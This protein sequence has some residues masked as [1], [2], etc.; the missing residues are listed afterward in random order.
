MENHEDHD[1]HEHVR[2]PTQEPTED[3]VLDEESTDESECTLGYLLLLDLL[4]NPEES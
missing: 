4:T 3:E 1:D 2:I